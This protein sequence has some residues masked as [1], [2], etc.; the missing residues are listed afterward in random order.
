MCFKCCLTS[1]KFSNC[2]NT[3]TLDEVKKRIKVIVMKQIKERNE[4]N[5]N[6]NNYNVNSELMN[7]YLQSRVAF[8]NV[9][10]N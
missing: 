7:L 4:Y 1:Y 5:Y 2:T 10:K 8:V 9:I 6:S 3:L